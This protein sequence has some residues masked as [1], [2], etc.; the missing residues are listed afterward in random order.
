VALELGGGV[1]VEIGNGVPFGVA[2]G[3][4]AATGVGVG[5]GMGVG[6]G[7]GVGVGVA[8]GTGVGVGVGNGVGVGVGGGG[9]EIS[10]VPASSVEA[11]SPRPAESKT[12]AF[13]PAGSVP[14]HWNWTPSFQEPPGIADI[15]CAAPLP[16]VTETPSAAESS[17]LRYQTVATTTVVVVPLRGET[18]G[19]DRRFGPLV[20]VAGR[21]SVSSNSA[22]A[23]MATANDHRSR[24]PL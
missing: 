19:L 3:V 21:T 16:N 10:T 6:V 20:A 13:E 23:A 8:V 2:P 14:D 5:V 18:S 22:A 11:K 1:G 12:T 4:A 9:D 15:V 7:L 24:V 17:R